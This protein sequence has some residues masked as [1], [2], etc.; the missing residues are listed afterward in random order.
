MKSNVSTDSQPIP[1]VA[2]HTDQGEPAAGSGEAELR[3][4][5][6][7][8]CPFDPPEEYKRLQDEA[9]V[10]RLAFPDGS[11]G[12]LDRKSTRLNSSH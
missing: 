8:G 7:R 12:W 2:P 3:L 6:T 4:P 10:S 11:Y 1:S 5:M 9:P